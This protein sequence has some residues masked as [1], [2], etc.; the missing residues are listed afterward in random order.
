SYVT[1]KVINGHCDCMFLVNAYGWEWTTI[2]ALVAPRPLLFANS[3]DDKIFPMDGNRRIIAR[4]RTLYK[5]YDKPDLVDEYVSKGDHNYRPDLRKAVF[6][7]INKHVKGDTGPVKDADFEPLPGKELRV[8]PEDK[9]VPADALN[10]KIDETFVPRAKV[11][12]PE[13]GKYDEWRKGLMKELRERSFRVFPDRIPK[14]EEASAIRA[15]EARNGWF[16]SP[17]TE[18]GIRCNLYLR[19]PAKGSPATQTLFVLDD[20]RDVEL[21]D[22]AR[23]WKDPGMYWVTYPRGGWTKKSPPNYV[24]QA[25]ALLGR[26]VDEGRVRDVAAIAALLQSAEIPELKLKGKQKLRVVGRGQTG[27]LAAYA[28]LFDPDVDE[29]VVVDPPAS[30]TEGPIFLNVLRVLDVPEALGMLAPRPLTVVGG[31]DKA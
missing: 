13:A 9:D 12:L 2:A 15:E 27:I 29:V 11:A 22:W 25:E 20:E 14:A 31:K 21:P 30:H 7:W 18:P 28:A 16:V 5:L 4:L 23:S 26:T 3:D 1:N 10:A 17:V 6:A 24:E 8:F 19:E